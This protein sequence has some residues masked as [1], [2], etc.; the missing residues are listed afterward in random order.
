MT[1]AFNSWFQTLGSRVSIRFRKCM[2]V[3]AGIDE[4]GHCVVINDKPYFLITTKFKPLIMAG[5][6]K[7]LPH[8][9]DPLPRP[10]R[11]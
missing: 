1:G 9:S 6:L 11:G 8:A 4:I 10:G 5:H 3:N 2:K 7:A